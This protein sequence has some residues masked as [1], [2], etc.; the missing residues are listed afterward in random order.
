MAVIVRFEADACKHRPPGLFRVVLAWGREPGRASGGGKLE[1]CR[2][3]R[4]RRIRPTMS[5]DYFMETRMERETSHIGQ[6]ALVVAMLLVGVSL[7]WFAP[8]IHRSL[9]EDVAAFALE[10]MGA[11]VRYDYQLDEDGKFLPDVDPPGWSWVKAIVGNSY[12]A[13]VTDIDLSLT[14]LMPPY[15]DPDDLDSLTEARM[16]RLLEFG[17]EEMAYVGQLTEIETLRLGDT[18]VTGAG[19]KY[20]RGLTRL[21]TLWLDG[22]RVEDSSLIHVAQLPN[23]EHLDLSRTRVSNDGLEHLARLVNLKQLDL[24]NTLVTE[25]GIFALRK[26]LPECTVNTV[27]DTFET[28]R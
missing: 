18:R 16:E 8:K 22:T 4:V 15:L 23:L 1:L 2:T 11:I 7:G 13:H 12:F 6:A 17:D 14:Y 21:K 9:Q 26:V 5:I 20:L 19:L 25:A 27:P 28:E 24:K 3:V 10:E